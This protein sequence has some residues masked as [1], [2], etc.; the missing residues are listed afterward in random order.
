MSGP[1][2]T[3][4]VLGSLN[5]DLVVTASRLPAAGET[6]IG[7]TFAVH[8]GGKGANQAV[9]AR[10]AG[11]R[12][13]MIGCVGDDAF[14]GELV[15]A[16]T[17]EGIDVSSLAVV[18]GTPTGVGLITVAA[19]GENTIVVASGANA[20]LDAARVETALGKPGGADILLAQFE[21]PLPG[22]A[23]A[24]AAARAAGGRVVLNAAPGV[25][26]DDAVRSILR[27]VDV[28]VV[29]E[30]EA[31]ILTG[32]EPG[33]VTPDVREVAEALLG[34][35]SCRVVVTLGARGAA[36][37]GPGFFSTCPAF[38]V[39]PVDTV[40][41]GDAFTG[42]LAAALVRGGSLE[43][44]LDEACAAG[45]L[46]TTRPGA[47]PSLPRREDIRRLVASGV[48]RHPVP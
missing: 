43:A 26:P 31:A 20:C 5:M 10:R 25:P 4:I 8:P 42:A 39:D 28:L 9:A 19:S 30:T 17:A 6:L 1:E 40:A 38:A 16:L 33:N 46:A 7:R 23:L 3:V 14:G 37:A 27:N 2:P 21:T 34:L 45:A 24:F 41:A 29:N 11:A 15:D 35:G 12:V 32:G 47:I 22:L 48:R 44:A 18:P 36:A 13:R